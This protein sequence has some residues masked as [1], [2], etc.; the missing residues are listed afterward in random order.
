MAEH[1]SGIGHG[2]GLEVRAP[3]QV[4]PRSFLLQC[5]PNFEDR[6]IVVW[7]THDLHA[8]G[9]SVVSQA[10]WNAQHW[11]AARH[12]EEH[13]G[14][15]ANQVVGSLAVDHEGEVLEAWASKK[16]DRKAALKFLQKSMKRY[17]RP[18]AI[19]TDRLPEAWI[20]RSGHTR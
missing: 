7:A 2:V 13:C 12:V 16:R 18:G 4:E 5:G 19:V 10:R 3:S 1:L 9:N 6:E 15:V 14:G 17:G 20:E 8:S 11:A